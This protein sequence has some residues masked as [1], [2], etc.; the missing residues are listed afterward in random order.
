MQISLPT[1]AKEKSENRLEKNQ[2]HSKRSPQSF[3]SILEKEK[4]KQE[5]DEKPQDST[6]HSAEKQKEAQKAL[7]KRLTESS[8]LS[9]LFHF[10]YDLAYKNPAEWSIAEREH[11]GIEKQ[12]VSVQ[13]FNRM[14][15]SRGLSIRD[16]S[17]DHLAQMSRLNN[18][19]ELTV[20]LDKLLLEM[21]SASLQD[22]K[23]TSTLDFGDVRTS[24]QTIEKESGKKEEEIIKEIV[25]QISL[26]KIREGTEVNIILNP[27]DLGDLKI[28]IVLNNDGVKA[29]FKTQN[30]DLR[31]LLEK[32]FR[33]LAKAFAKQ[34]LE[35]KELKVEKIL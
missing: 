7:G 11:Y 28:G 19:R 33:E 35:I 3:S 6:S 31:I 10:L 23:N 25:K 14:L 8:A 2:S 18:R 5:K 13:E 32:N 22:R 4:T 9:G 20:F 30:D 12:G 17:F 1:L 21:E 27:K 24:L 34:G 29:L 16:L 26:R 15:S